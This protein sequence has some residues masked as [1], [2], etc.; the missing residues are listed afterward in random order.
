MFSDKPLSTVTAVSVVEANI[1]F[2]LANKARVFLSVRSLLSFFSS[3]HPLVSHRVHHLITEYTVV[4]IQS[5]M[6]TYDSTPY[7]SSGSFMTSSVVTQPPRPLT[8]SSLD[9]TPST[10]PPRSPF[11]P[12]RKHRS[13]SPPPPATSPLPR[14]TRSTQMAPPPAPSRSGGAS[15]TSSVH[16]SSAYTA[17][18]PTTP[19]HQNSNIPNLTLQTAS[20]RQTPLNITRKVLSSNSQAP[21][22]TPTT[23][24]PRLRAKITPAA[25]PRRKNVLPGTENADIPVRHGG[26]GG[27]NNSPIKRA[28]PPLA[29]VVGPS[30]GAFPTTTRAYDDDYEGGME[31]V[32]RGLNGLGLSSFV[33]MGLGGVNSSP[34]MTRMV[35]NGG[36]K[37]RD[38]VLVCVR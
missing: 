2:L 1:L 17:G 31:E 4:L 33:E 21:P 27:G 6:P 3:S 20:P 18:P 14:S 8:P 28:P 16:S 35:R 7:D 38:S 19:L 5:T 13:T 22:L 36:S 10:A 11:V 15:T 25:T 24:A 26:G 9:S 34:T 12:V 37:G 29:A 32:Q 30:Y 23:A